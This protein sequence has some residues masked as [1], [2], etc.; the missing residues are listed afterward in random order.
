MKK[1]ALSL[2]L[3]FVLSAAASLTAEVSAK[4]TILFSESFETDF[5]DL[6]PGWNYYSVSTTAENIKADREYA[7]DGQ[8]GLRLTKTVDTVP[9]GIS[10]SKITAEPGKTYTAQT[11]VYLHSGSCSLYLKFHDGAG[12]EVGTKSV[13]AVSAGNW[14]EL[15]VSMEAPENTAFTFVILYIN[16]ASLG[17]ATFDRV[18]LMELSQSTVLQNDPVNSRLVVPSDSAL[19]YPAYNEQGDKLSDFSHAGFYAGAVELPATE[20]LP[21]AVTVSPS[22]DASGDDRIRLQNIINETAAA[23]DPSKMTVIKLE[24]GRYNISAPGIT[25]KSGIVLSGAGQGPN[26]TVLYASSAQQYSAVKPAGSAL[27]KTGADINIIDNYVKAGSNIFHVEDSSSL[28]AG[29]LIT[30]VH[31]SSAEWCKGMEMSAIRNVYGDDTSWGEG[32]VD[33]STERTIQSIQGNQ[34]TLDFPLF[35][36]LNKSYAQSYLYKT[37]DSG[38]IENFGV[39]NLRIESYYNGNPDDEAHASAAVNISYAKNGFIRNV[40]AKYFVLNAVACGRNSKQITVQNCSSLQPVSQMAG[41]RRYSFACSTSAQQILITGCYSYD[42]RHDFEA[43]YPATGPLVYLDNIA[44]SSNT[45]SETHGTWSTGLLYENLYQVGAGSKGFI[46][47]ANRG[48]YGTKLSQGWSAAGCVA[49]NCLSSTIIAHKPPLSYQNFMIGTWGVYQDSA[50]QAM[51]NANLRS[52]QGIYRTDSVYT[53]DSSYFETNSNTPFAGD[54]YREA[55]SNPVEPR[56][57]YKAQL[58]QRMTGDYRNVRPNAPILL[59]PRA[60]E[61]L[62]GT[63]IKLNGIYQKGASAVTVYIDDEP[64]QAVLQEDDNTFQLSLPLSQGWHKVYSTQTVDGLEST[65]S[66]DRFVK[67]GDSGEDYTTSSSYPREKTS[68]IAND[69]RFSFD[70]LGSTPET[71]TVSAPQE[72]LYEGVPFDLTQLSLNAADK[73]GNPVLLTA[74]QK[75]SVTWQLSSASEIPAE[76]LTLQNGVLTVPEGILQ[77]GEEKKLFITASLSDSEAGKPVVSPEI[78]LRVRQRSKCAKLTV[79]NAPDGASYRSTLALNTLTVKAL[80]QYGAEMTAPDNLAWELTNNGSQAV[81]RENILSFGS[82]RG[83]VTLTAKSGKIRS[84]GISIPVGPDVKQL[85]ASRTSLSASG[86][87]VSFS[88]SGE[89]LQDSVTVSAFSGNSE[90][91][92]LSSSSEWNGKTASAK[93]TFPASTSSKQTVYT[94][95]ISYDGTLFEVSPSVSV[96]VAAST[97]G[98]NHGGGGGGGGGGGIR[99]TATPTPAPTPTAAPSASPSTEPVEA[100]ARFEDVNITDWFCPA[101]N[102]VYEK[103]LFAGTDE[104]HFEPESPMTRGMLVTVLYRLEGSEEKDASVFS[105][106]VPGEWYAAPASWAAKNNIVTGVGDNRFAPEDNIT[107]EQLAT[108]FYKYAVFLGQD[109][110][111]SQTELPFSDREQIS[112]WAKEA[113][114][115]AVNVGLLSGKENNLLDPGGDATRAEVAAVLQRFI[116]WRAHPVAS[117]SLLPSSFTGLLFQ[118]QSHHLADKF[119]E[120]AITVGK[121]S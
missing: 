110:L 32:K 70:R 65:K 46:A 43:S 100:S 68:L 17:D 41:S 14:E 107:R 73:S 85:S 86:G 20:N 4:E 76:K 55:E 114:I 57:L 82:V 83:T 56:S 7:S 50:S 25:L 10:C 111:V 77:N 115:W 31:P 66:A 118:K 91:P 109:S 67:L 69:P 88:L 81:M 8:Q 16:K 104:T 89:R 19:T 87:T 59:T 23:A 93:L 79:E 34:I 106:V 90:T 37:D 54:A 15:S 48:V 120:Y 28:Q 71:L 9:A 117:A 51:K 108:I 80:D 95:R 12:K 30:I 98:G 29:D 52:Y 11:D 63:V 119:F 5:S 38:R 102:F 105:D 24:P 116:A 36:P 53:A 3:A 47:M 61:D 103:G 40:S 84:S 78:T 6:P 121:M 1:K 44:D 33:M 13:S 18:R 2:L 92:L 42:G 113:C 21:V 26:G 58:A 49:W 22:A 112:G 75:A 45:A 60:E 39:E 27:K 101:V 62:T 99:P 74:A 72:P 97:A 94:V 96:T 35:V 64:H